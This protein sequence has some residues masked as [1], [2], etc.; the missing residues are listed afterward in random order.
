MKCLVPRCKAEAVDPPRDR[1]NFQVPPLPLCGEHQKRYR[2]EYHRHFDPIIRGLSK[3]W[4]VGIEVVK[5]RV[6]DVFD[7]SA[8]ASRLM[9]WQATWV[10]MVDLELLNSGNALG[11]QKGRWQ[12]IDGE[13]VWVPDGSTPRPSAPRPSAP[14]GSVKERYARLPEEATDAGKAAIAKRQAEE[15]LL[16]QRLRHE[17]AEFAKGQRQ[18]LELELKMKREAER[19]RALKKAKA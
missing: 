9:S 6:H 10:Q 3:R 19:R 14:P 11:T 16:E 8:K 12:T 7:E 2:K 18:V 17:T 15:N 5:G 4:K 1:K 13:E